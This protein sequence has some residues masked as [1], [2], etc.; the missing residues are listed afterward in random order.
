MNIGFM[1]LN[2]KRYIVPHWIEVDET[3][4]YDNI[5][6]YVPENRKISEPKIETFKVEG[7]PYVIRVFNG[8]ISCNCP[9]FTFHRKCKHV[10]AFKEGNK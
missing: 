5:L 4:T 2:G 6:D 7:K 1:N 8:T 9:G 10:T 3:V